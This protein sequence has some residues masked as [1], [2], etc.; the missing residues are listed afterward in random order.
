MF[1]ISIAT[2]GKPMTAEMPATTRTEPQHEY[3]QQQGH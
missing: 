2:A 3:Q 1:N